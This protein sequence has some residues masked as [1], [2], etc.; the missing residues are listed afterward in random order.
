MAQYSSYDDVNETAFLRDFIL[1]IT[2][3]DIGSSDGNTSMILM[4]GKKYCNK[5]LFS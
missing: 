3:G 4:K 5:T 1:C 2:G